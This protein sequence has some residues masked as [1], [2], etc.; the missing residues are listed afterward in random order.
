MTHSSNSRRTVGEPKPT[1]PIHP[2]PHQLATD[3][4]W[5]RRATSASSVKTDPNT[6]PT[7]ERTVPGGRDPRGLPPTSR[8]DRKSTRLNSSHVATSYAVFCLKKK[9]KQKEP[10]PAPNYH[11]HTQPRAART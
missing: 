6:M 9:K 11:T 7:T 3:M 8:I 5:P 10:Q 2:T 1:R 4:F